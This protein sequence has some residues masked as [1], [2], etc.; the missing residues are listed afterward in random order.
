M[1]VNV[2]QNLNRNVSFP[3]GETKKE[4]SPNREA[5]QKESKNE[6]LKSNP[7]TTTQVNSDK[8]SSDSSSFKKYLPVI[9][10]MAA[11]PISVLISHKLSMKS[12]DGLKKEILKSEK[13]TA[14]ELKKL[15]NKSSESNKVVDSLIG[16]LSG[17]TAGI[18]GSTL[19]SKN[20]SEQ[21]REEKINKVK[22]RFNNIEQTAVAANN[23]ANS[24]KDSA[25]AANGKADSAMLLNNNALTSKYLSS[26][27]GIP[28][29]NNPDVGNKDENAF[30]KAIE[31][32]QKVAANHLTRKPK[33]KPIEEKNPVIW[34]VT[35]E[36]A[37]IKT[38]GLGSVPV[39]V[40]T[41][42][43][44]LGVN[45]PTFIPMYQQAG[46]SSFI[47][48]NGKYFYKYGNT[49]FRLNKVLS[50]S[51]DSFR[52]GVS[53]PEEVEI[54][55]TKIKND[56]GKEKQLIFIKNDSYFNDG[57]YNAN[58]K[59]EEPEKFA[60]FS[61]AVYELLKIKEDSSS[62]INLEVADEDALNEIKSPDGLILN[63]WQA[64]PIAAL[65]RYK[66][67]MENAFKKLSAQAKDKISNMR[68]VTIGHNAEYQGSTASYNRG[69]KNEATSNVLNTL[70]D[71]YA[72]VIVSNANSG[73]S[74]TNTKDSGLK[75][76][77]NVLLIN[78]DDSSQNHTNLL[79]MGICLSDYF[80]PVS[81]N[82][83]H[84][85]VTD[86]KQSGEL[87]WAI[88]TKHDKAKAVV[89]IINGNDFKDL[90]I[91]GKRGKSIK[92]LTNLDFKTYNRKSSI[93]DLI[94]A[95]TANKINFYNNY[96]KLL[97]NKDNKKYADSE[98]MKKL[99]EIKQFENLENVGETH[100]PDLTDEELKNTPI[101][102][103]VGRLVSQKG[104]DVMAESIRNILENWEENFPGKNKPIFYLAGGDGEG[105]VHKRCLRNLKESLNAEDSNRIVFAH[106]MAPMT[107]MQAASDFFLV[108]SYFE[109]CGL[110]QGESFAVGTPVIASKVG[111]LVDTVNR[112]GK[113][114]G[115]LTE[116]PFEKTAMYNNDEKPKCIE[117]FTNAMNEALDIYFNDKEQYNKMVKDSIDED[118]SW[119]QK[120]KKGPV[121]EYLTRL[122]IPLEN[123]PDVKA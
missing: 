46:K 18:A 109:P 29:L 41:N 48:K 50:Y 20:N 5:L 32:I 2:V 66:A 75:N 65:A 21:S 85:L 10:P 74:K 73:A 82:Y 118:F 34:S 61:K 114:N 117:Q 113:Q 26:F 30:N 8:N 42:A 91:E 104:S 28:L 89:G 43:T 68:I 110:V 9:L 105:G 57:I 63:D 22:T 77:D 106:G 31:N 35:S 94:S 71:N 51:I 14:E 39:E 17:A 79:N 72:H 83:V 40:Q 54:Y 107:A 45:M 49:E 81:Q 123:L 76:L 62:A 97:V 115:I 101:I 7:I 4:N 93:A 80:H 27:N 44:K 52:H 108:P 12:I 84:E 92:G 47:N 67:P 19:S 96:M 13:L 98:Q 69:E 95:R 120:G 55:S 90:N 58:N 86:P 16:A 25:A 33:I 59:T 111:G 87:A 56:D 70:F 53:R 37:P 112:N 119:I 122:G 24:A 88:K 78:Q 102:T 116:E 64:S 100:L 6:S 36:F 11:I 99:K 60:F 103:F 38:G 23:N 121:Y 1:S 3:I 15:T